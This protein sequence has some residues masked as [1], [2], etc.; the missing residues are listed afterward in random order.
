MSQNT[1]GLKA[2]DIVFFKQDELEFI[3]LVICVTSK[4]HKLKCV[5][6]L[7]IYLIQT[8]LSIHIENI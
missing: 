2:G 3:A 8:I 6:I 4:K 5:N 7:M 1:R